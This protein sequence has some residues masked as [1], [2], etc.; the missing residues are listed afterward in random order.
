M[1]VLILNGARADA[2]TA[3][4]RSPLLLAAE[5]GSLPVVEAL[6]DAGAPLDTR[7][8]RGETPLGRAA[9]G[10]HAAVVALLLGAAVLACFLPASR[11]SRVDPAIALRYE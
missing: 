7:A 9:A 4:G 2:V 10:G 3:D 5:A 11:A 6:A 8:T 1:N